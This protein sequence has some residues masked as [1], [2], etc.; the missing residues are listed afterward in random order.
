MTIKMYVAQLIV[1]VYVA[2]IVIIHQNVINVIVTDQ[3]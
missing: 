1:V 2:A 3:L